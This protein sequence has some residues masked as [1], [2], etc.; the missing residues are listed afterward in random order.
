MGSYGDASTGRIW[1]IAILPLFWFFRILDD[2]TC[3]I[4]KDRKDPS[5]KTLFQTNVSL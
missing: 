4:L 2:D 5:D 1:Q 3:G